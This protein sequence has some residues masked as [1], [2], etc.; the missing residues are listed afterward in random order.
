MSKCKTVKGKGKTIKK[1]NA[2]ER[3]KVS[4]GGK[5]AMKTS[6]KK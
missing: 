6:K 3:K 5:M 1:A 4:N 2:M